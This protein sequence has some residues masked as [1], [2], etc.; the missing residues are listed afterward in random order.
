MEKTVEALT[1]EVQGLRTVRDQKIQ[2]EDKAAE[3][4]QK[5][6]EKEAELN[7]LKAEIHN[8]MK[9]GNSS[10]G[11]GSS[12]NNS[13]ESAAEQFDL[14]KEVEQ[15]ASQFHAQVDILRNTVKQ[16]GIENQNTTD[17]YG[18]NVDASALKS[19]EQ[20]VMDICM[21]CMRSLRM[22]GFNVWNLI[23]ATL[24]TSPNPDR[25]WS[26]T[27]TASR[28]HMTQEQK[29]RALVLRK[30]Y[31]NKLKEIY[32]ERQGLNLQAISVL[33]PKDQ[34]G[35][36]PNLQAGGNPYSLTGFFARARHNG[37][38]NSVLEQLRENLRT[39]QRAASELDYIV[40][41]RLFTP[42]QASWFVLEC[43]PEHCDCLEFLNGC[44]QAFGQDINLC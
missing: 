32:N 35:Q 41:H 22:E 37:K 42:I 3:L 40:F 12:N 24:Q 27:S 44:E 21:V 18:S 39:E 6:V 25:N 5:L 17:I 7:R 29:Q 2:L 26:S 30:D 19:I 34:G 23:Q 4:E 11:D 16:N 38:M 31:L 1:V 14:Q 9:G 10:V 8:H 20:L 28:L 13:G 33:L 36:G 43:Y 15:L